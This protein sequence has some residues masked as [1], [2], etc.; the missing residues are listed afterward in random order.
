PTGTCWLPWWS[1]CPT[2]CPRRST[3]FRVFD[4]AFVDFAASGS[5]DV[6]RYRVVEATPSQVNGTNFARLDA[7]VLRIEPL[8]DGPQDVPDALTVSPDPRGP[9]RHLSSYR[10]LGYPRQP[11]YE[12]R[13]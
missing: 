8:P 12:P 13:H 2:R 7:A 3:G 6:R 4:G 5:A 10:M 1:G 9:L 11:A